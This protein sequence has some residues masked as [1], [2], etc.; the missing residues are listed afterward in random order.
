VDVCEHLPRS[1]LDAVE[2]HWQ[3]KTQ[4]EETD[5]VAGHSTGF[6][7]YLHGYKI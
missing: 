1:K 3:T 5:A 4:N 2:W 7:P 6:L